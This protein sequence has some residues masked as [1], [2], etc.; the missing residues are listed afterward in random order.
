MKDILFLLSSNVR[1]QFRHFNSWRTAVNVPLFTVAIIEYYFFQF[2]P[3]KFTLLATHFDVLSVVVKWSKCCQFSSAQLHHSFFQPWPDKTFKLYV[4][5][6]TKIW[7]NKKS[8]YP[9]K[10]LV[11]YLAVRPSKN[12]SFCNILGR[13]GTSFCTKARLNL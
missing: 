13:Q 1:L 6:P 4:C 9:A 8:A 7:I 10:V 5:A 2:F 11:S 12:L 3:T